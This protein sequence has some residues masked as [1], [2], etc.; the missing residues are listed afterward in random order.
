[1]KKTIISA[2]VAVSTLI[3]TVGMSFGD[4]LVPVMTYRVG[5][6]A[7][8]GTQNANGF[9]DYLTML[10]ERDGGIGGVKIKVEECE[11]GYRAEKGVECYESYRGKNPLV[12]T[13]NS[14]GI[15]LQILA[16]AP[17]DK[18]PILTMGY[19]LSAAAKGETFPWAFN[20]PTSY[21]SQMTSILKYIDSQ[22]GLKDQKIGF[23]FLESGY[24]REPIPV[25]EQLAPKFGFEYFLLPVAGK[26]AQNQSSH[27]LTVRKEKPDWMIMWGW[28]VMNP[29]AVKAAIKSRYP[30]DRFVGNWWSAGDVDLGPIGE[31]GKG[32]KGATFNS[33]GTDFPAV[34]DVIKYVVSKGITKTGSEGPGTVL[35]N[36]AMWNAALIAEAIKTAQ[37]ITGKKEIT[38][39]D[40]RIGLENFVL[41]EARLKE[42]GFAGMVAPI[43]G[44][45]KDHE[46]AGAAF[47]QQWDGSKWVKITDAIDPMKDIAQ[48][49]LTKAAAQYASNNAGWTTQ[50]C[51]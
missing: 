38:G 32:Y 4:L 29:T 39:E 3:T 46:G 31:A 35:Y 23:I 5:P 16:K 21:F 11:T 13:P 24:G 20:Y 34:Q 41:D 45:C 27:W 49:M 1:M 40:M 19:G 26:D 8:N 50:T 51:N 33:T 36:R 6:F 7:A 17:E 42:L 10:N 2:F 25:L 28:G 48:E 15:T 43:V 47:I 37:D 18:T 44:S 22:T 30:L 9:V 12:H 14:T